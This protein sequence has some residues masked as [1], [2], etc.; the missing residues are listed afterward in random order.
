MDIPESQKHDTISKISQMPPDELEK[1]LGPKCIFCGI[2]Q[3]QMQAFRIAE[4]DDAVVVLELNPMTKGHVMLIP[5]KHVAVSELSS[6]TY[7]LL[8]QTL[9][10]LKERLKP[11]EINISSSQIE[12]HTVLNILP[13]SGQE[14]GKREKANPEDLKKLEDMLK[15]K[16]TKSEEKEKLIKEEETKP[17]EEKHEKT[18]EEKKPKE[19]VMET[20]KSE[21]EIIIEKSPIRVP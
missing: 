4:N 2:A 6:G 13:L 3:K 11:I 1:Y 7:D 21:P 18:E 17:E 8:Q 15:F 9:K 16:P 5:K 14:S 10:I 19:V 20:G 12:G